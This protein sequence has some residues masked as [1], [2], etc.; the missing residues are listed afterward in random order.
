MEHPP[1]DIAP[2][3][4]R[5]SRRQLGAALAHPRWRPLTEGAPLIL[6]LVTA[7]LAL[8]RFS[9]LGSAI[10]FG[11]AGSVALAFRDPERHIPELPQVA[12]APADGR[13]IRIGSV[14]DE[15]WGQ[16][17]T[18][19]AIFLSLWDV[20]VQRVPLAGRITAQIRYAGGYRPA[21]TSA[22]AYGNNRVA[23]YMETAS[24]PCTVMQISG[25]VARRIVTWA[26]AGD[27][28]EQG[29]RLGMIKFG[30]Q[31]TLRLPSTAHILVERGTPVRAG[32]TSVAG[33]G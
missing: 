8:S 32:L 17:M 11:G 18:E 16:E 19:V 13:V 3:P 28:L 15:Y 10:A 22:A 12:L 25:L 26:D 7:G 20:H 14:W 1:R 24:G 29:E 6:P 4:P 2:R 30:S 31:V 23:T 9:R 33:V 5:L 27:E 21:M